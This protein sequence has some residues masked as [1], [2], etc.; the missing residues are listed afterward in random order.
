METV[1]LTGSW[2]R[3]LDGSNL[4]PANGFYACDREL[5]KAQHWFRFTGSAGSQMSN[6]CP[7]KYSCGSHGGFWT[8]APMPTVVGEI[9]QVAIYGS[10]NGDCSWYTW[11]QTNSMLVQKCSERPGDY[12]YKVLGTGSCYWTFCGMNV[13]FD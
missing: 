12:I 5:Q 2:R 4:L 8:N 13:D 10:W 11:P 9:H 3:D 1:N 7:V 6:R